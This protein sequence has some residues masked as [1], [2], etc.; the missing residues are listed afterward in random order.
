MNC[1]KEI[2]KYFCTVILIV[3]ILICGTLVGIIFLPSDVFKDDYENVIQAKYDNLVSIEEPKI[4]ICAGSS[5]AF[6]IDE[7]MLEEATGYKVANMGVHA[8]MGRLFTTEIVK[9][10][11]NEGDILLLAYEYGWGKDSYSK[12]GI[13]TIMNGIDSDIRILGDVPIQNWSEIIG[14]LPEFAETK[15]YR[16]NHKA[17]EGTY[18]RSSFDEKGKMILER[19]SVVYKEENFAKVTESDLSLINESVY[20]LRE[21]KEMVEAKGARVYFVAPPLYEESYEGNE[22]AL[23]EMV[24]QEE[25]QIGIPYISDPVDYLFPLDLMFDTQYHCNDYGEDYR[26]ELLI[27]DLEKVL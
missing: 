3:V 26:T 12:L 8:G 24:K 4:I 11:I 25:E 27:K 7:E 9:R 6:G 21:T 17:P 19:P 23:E 14:Y 13:N 20:Y 1:K 18:S 22:E 15:A 16:M 5:A 2:A 10:H